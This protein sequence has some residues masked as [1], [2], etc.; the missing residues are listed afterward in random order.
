M[1]AL[2]LGCAALAAAQPG[3]ALV[4]AGDF[5]LRSSELPELPGFSAPG[6]GIDH[7]LVRGASAGPIEVWPEAERTTEV[8]VLSDH[9]PI[10]LR[11]G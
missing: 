4:F 9:A 1:L 7:I 10:Q 11:V 6:P 8:G 3:D 2:V 5:N